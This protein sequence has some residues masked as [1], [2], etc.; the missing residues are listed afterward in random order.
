MQTGTPAFSSIQVMQGK[1]HTVQT[2]LES[3]FY[4][5]TFVCAEGKL[6][7]SQRPFSHFERIGILEHGWDDAILKIV[8]EGQAIHMLNKLQE[9]FVTAKRYDCSHASIDAFRAILEKYK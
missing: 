1:G 9:L 7:W 8:K 5:I 3:I 4:T 2:E 6:P